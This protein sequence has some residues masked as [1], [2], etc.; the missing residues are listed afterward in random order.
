METTQ[1]YLTDTEEQEFEQTGWTITN[2][3]L[4]DWAI[5]KIAQA[6]AEIDRFTEACTDK[7]NKLS[8][9]LKEVTDKQN[10]SIDFFEYKLKEYIE[11]LDI[12][13]SKAGTKI[14]NLPSGKISIKP[15]APKFTV[16]NDDFIAWLKLTGKQDLI[17]CT[18]TAQWGELKKSGIIVG[19]D[20]TTVL[21]ADGELVT[22]VTAE[23][24]EDV[25]KVEV[26]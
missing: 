18:E 3:E 13:A 8:I 16:T 26:L 20:G 19:E 9:R 22:G 24:R 15:Q 5:E 25:V 12:K 4:A 7:I 11:T 23:L 14:Y 21:T 10:K 6:Q 17:K 2:D 1:E